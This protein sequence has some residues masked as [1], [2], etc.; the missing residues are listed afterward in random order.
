MKV[1]VPMP[2]SVLTPHRRAALVSL[3]AVVM[4]C[5]AISASAAGSLSY[6]TASQQTNTRLFLASFVDTMPA[7]AQHWTGNDFCQWTGVTCS[8]NGVS[9]GA[10]RMTMLHGTS[11]QLPNVPAGVVASEVMLTTF[12]FS[13]ANLI[14]GTL[15]PSW[16]ALTRLVTLSVGGNNMSGTLPD[17]LGNLASLWALN[18]FDNS[19]TGTIPA[20]WGQLSACTL[21]ALYNNSLSGS[22]PVAWNQL[23]SIKTIYVQDNHLSGSL[24]TAWENMTSLKTLYMND[25]SFTGSLPAEWGNMAS[26]SYVTVANNNLCGCV[27]AAW[28]SRGVTILADNAVTSDDC[29]TANI[30]VQP[31]TTTSTAPKPTKTTTTSSTTSTTSKA[32]QPSQC[33]VPNC[34]VCNSQNPHYCKSCKAGYELTPAFMCRERAEDVASAP[35]YGVGT[36]TLVLAA[37]LIVA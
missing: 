27:P 18:L 34:A 10:S 20:S 33:A 1:C 23:K 30:C 14:S 2:L 28:T 16:G 4:A 24:P 21:I 15:P 7:L 22:L 8:R 17:E 37:T 25:N 26:I 31:T 12:S 32:P 11:V 36:L 19:F 9:I 6:Y 5:C 3:V 35:L 29:A 13:K